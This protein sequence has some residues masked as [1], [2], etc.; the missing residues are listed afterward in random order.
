MFTV[1]HSLVLLASTP[2][3]DFCGIKLG[4]G[5]VNVV[6]GVDIIALLSRHPMVVAAVLKARSFRNICFVT[7]SVLEP[8][9]GARVKYMDRQCK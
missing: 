3:L 9:P 7:D 2:A 1:H 8:V 5:L 4:R 6:H